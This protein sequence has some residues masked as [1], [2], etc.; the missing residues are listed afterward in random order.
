MLILTYPGWRGQG[1]QIVYKK[2]HIFDFK[3]YK[4]YTCTNRVEENVLVTMCG[5]GSG[6]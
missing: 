1:K 2:K 6:S 3:Q 4:K 5:V